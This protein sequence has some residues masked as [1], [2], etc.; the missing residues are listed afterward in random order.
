[1]KIFK[2]M[3]DAE[4]GPLLVGDARESPYIISQVCANWRAIVLGACPEVWAVMRVEMKTGDGGLGLKAWDQ[5]VVTAMERAGSHLLDLE[6]HGDESDPSNWSSIHC[7]QYLLGEGYQWRM[8]TLNIGPHH[9]L[10]LEHLH[11]YCP[12]VQSTSVHLCTADT[13]QTCN[14]TAFS[15]TTDL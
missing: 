3:K 2:A 12:K 14:I 4:D 13:S 15:F 11:D 1:M 5:L 10:F 6:F 7:F 9:L 8:A